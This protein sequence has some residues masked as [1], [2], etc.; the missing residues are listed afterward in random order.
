M[1]KQDYAKTRSAIR[2]W[3]L[4]KNYHV[5]LAAMEFGLKYHTGLRKDGKMPEFQH[6]ISQANFARTLETVLMYPEEVLSTIFLHD[7]VEDIEGV[8]YADVRKMLR[9]SGGS[10]EMV[11]RILSG[12]EKMTNQ[13]PDEGIKKPK[14]DYYN[15]M[16]DCPISS[17]CKGIDRIHNHQ[18]MTDAFT[19]EK[20]ESYI[21]E[22]DDYILPML[23]QARYTW[24]KQEPAYQNIKTVLVAQMEMVEIIVAAGKKKT[25][26]KQAPK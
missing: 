26:K 18:T 14:A 2:Y 6:Q 25:S 10:E 13:W 17:L 21:K 19:I 11:S 16:I 24:T 3:M 22:T 7:V 1:K 20:Q 12:V 9:K 8:G 23:K 5:A 15:S 4:G